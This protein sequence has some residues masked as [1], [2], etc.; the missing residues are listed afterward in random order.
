[1]ADVALMITRAIYK[2]ACNWNMFD[3]VDDEVQA[4]IVQG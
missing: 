4:E 1:M 3:E 2:D